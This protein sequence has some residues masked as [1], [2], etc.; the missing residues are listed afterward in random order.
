MRILIRKTADALFWAMSYRCQ[1]SMIFSSCRTS[2]RATGP[3]GPRD[4]GENRAV[5]MTP[6]LKGTLRAVALPRANH[7]ARRSWIWERLGLPPL[8][9]KARGMATS[10]ATGRRELER[11]ARMAA[12]SDYFC[13]R[14]E[15]GNQDAATSP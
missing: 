4:D 11:Q 3:R 9:P 15:M 13:A 5:L 2:I 6:T 1:R 10:S 14:H 8:K 12:A 7:G